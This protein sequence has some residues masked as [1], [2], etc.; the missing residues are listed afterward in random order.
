MIGALQKDDLVAHALYH[1]WAH[2]CRT[3]PALAV[4]HAAAVADGDECLIL[5]APGGSGKTT[6]TAVLLAQGW[7]LFKR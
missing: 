5:A 1:M 7:A 6:L 3:A 2:T 4:L